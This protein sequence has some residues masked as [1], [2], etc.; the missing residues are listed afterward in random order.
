MLSAAPPADVADE[1]SISAAVEAVKEQIGA[2]GLNLLINNAAINKPASPASLL[3]SGK[4]DMMEVFETNVVGPFLLTKVG[5][6]QLCL[7]L[8]CDVSRCARE[9]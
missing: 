3:T 9:K 7:W 1:R 4:K 6:P 8:H 2:S 5:S